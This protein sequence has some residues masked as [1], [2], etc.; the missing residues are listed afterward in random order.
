MTKRYEQA[1]VESRIE[2]LQ[3]LGSRG[4]TGLRPGSLDKATPA[5]RIGWPVGM[6]CRVASPKLITLQWSTLMNRGRDNVCCL[7]LCI[8]SCIPYL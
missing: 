6:I 3:K 5:L 7:A 2:V 1:E 4:L 8:R